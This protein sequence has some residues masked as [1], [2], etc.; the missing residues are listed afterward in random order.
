MSRLEGVVLTGFNSSLI[1]SD[2]S[3]ISKWKH[4]Y[5]WPD[6]FTSVVGGQHIVLDWI[7]NN[8]NPLQWKRNGSIEIWGTRKT[9]KLWRLDDRVRAPPTTAGHYKPNLAQRRT[10]PKSGWSQGQPVWQVEKRC[11]GLF[12][13]GLLMTGRIIVMADHVHHVIQTSRVKKSIIIIINQC[14]N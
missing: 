14:S 13:P 1:Q 4:L 5:Q 11:A 2:C 8:F 6:F 9:T 10:G 7:F 12:L 3:F